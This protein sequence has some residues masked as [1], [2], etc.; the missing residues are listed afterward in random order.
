MAPK[1]KKGGKDKKGGGD[2]GDDPAVLAQIEKQKMA[3][4]MDH[5]SHRMKLLLHDQESMTT[6]KVELRDKIKKEN[7]KH[8]HI[9]QHLN[10][11][12]I[13]KENELTELRRQ[14]RQSAVDH[15]AQVEDVVAQMDR[16][17]RLSAT[18]VAELNQQIRNLMEKTER[19]DQYDALNQRTGDLQ[20]E[21]EET[22]RQ[23]ADTREELDA[24]QRQTLVLTQ[25]L[26][27][28]SVVL[29]LLESMRLYPKLEILQVEAL[30]A[31]QNVVSPENPSEILDNCAMIRE[32][33]GI[34]IVLG[35]MRDN[36]TKDRVQCNACSLL[37]KLSFW[38]SENIPVIT[39]NGGMHLI[40]AA[41]TAH[42]DYAKLQYA[43]AGALRAIMGPARAAN[44]R[45]ARSPSPF[46]R[47]PMVEP[48]VP[49]QSRI[50]TP[51]VTSRFPQIDQNKALREEK[52]MSLAA[53][54]ARVSMPHPDQ[55]S[56]SDM[57]SAWARMHMHAMQLLLKC[58]ADHHDHE[59]IQTYA[60]GALMNI[61]NSS[62]TAINAAGKGGVITAVMGAM[63]THS[64][65]GELQ[66]VGLR[67][68]TRLAS[69]K[70]NR[71]I[72]EKSGGK[73]LTRRAIEI[74]KGNALVQSAAN[75]MKK[76][77]KSWDDDSDDDEGPS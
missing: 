74:H 5:L 18:R 65:N 41:M 50:K 62:D 22:R 55:I 69:V 25:P 33:G 58:M 30:A 75:E 70:Q 46:M 57:A 29:L 21:L 32:F 39:A 1:K 45:D 54:P 49:A 40:L 77:L 37:W 59:Y 68:L 44:D 76:Y 61:V 6:Q 28:D 2:V 3:V 8:E 51:V 17:Q 26:Y 63:R 64:E 12:I 9:Y 14:L 10:Q 35:A 53:M 20:A 24:W 38:D 19:V 31:L 67:T 60:I 48:P 42:P 66:M 23:L 73:E 16:E 34:G 27:R 43:A 71:K 52:Q 11:Q 7:T 4:E 72:V 47:A 15:A 13:E 36:L 56:D